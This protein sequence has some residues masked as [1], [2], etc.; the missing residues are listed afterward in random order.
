MSSAP[1]PTTTEVIESAVIRAPLSNVWH[2]IKLQNFADFW[3]ALES[4]QWVKG[5][6]D[7][8]DVVRWTFKDG[9]ELEVKQDEHSASL[10]TLKLQRAIKADLITL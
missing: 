8:T 10:Y 1:I 3:G 4:S 6:S 2:L 5:A 7:E 9:T